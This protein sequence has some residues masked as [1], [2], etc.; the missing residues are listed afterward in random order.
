MNCEEAVH[1]LD[2]FVDRELSSEEIQEVQRHLLLLMRPIVPNGP[3]QMAPPAVIATV[4]A[5]PA[6]AVADAGAAPPQPAPTVSPDDVTIPID[7]ESATAAAT[8]SA[9]I[10]PEPTEAPT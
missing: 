1:L 7:V 6:V 9:G 8:P 2:Q 4:G 5:A 3:Q 10:S